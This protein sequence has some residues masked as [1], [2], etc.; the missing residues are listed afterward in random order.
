MGMVAYLVKN[1]LTGIILVVPLLLTLLA[2]G[3]HK[4]P[5]GDRLLLFAVPVFFLYIGKAVEHLSVMFT[6]RCALAGFVLGLTTTVTVVFL[7][8]KQA[9]GTVRYPHNDEDIKSVLTYVA[10]RKQPGDILYIYYS[11]IPA[12]SYYAPQF[13]LDKLTIVKGIGSRDNPVAYMDDV[14]Q[15][16]GKGRAW[17][18]FSHNYNWGTFDE[19]A[20]FYD[21]SLPRMGTRLDEIRS[22]NAYAFLYS[23]R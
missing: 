17:F 4:Y 21:Y 12:F 6:G 1:R 7:S 3:L 8:A 22:V 9:I 14:A 15:L 5:F 10:Q 16:R 23:V 20:F 11:S 18:I 13:G 19:V 2:S